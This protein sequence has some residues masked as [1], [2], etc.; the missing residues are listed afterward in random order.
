LAALFFS[1]PQFI[2]RTTEAPFLKLMF[3]AI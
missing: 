1:M 2:F 3:R